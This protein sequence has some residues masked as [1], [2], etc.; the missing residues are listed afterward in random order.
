MTSGSNNSGADDIDTSLAPPRSKQQLQEQ[1]SSATATTSSWSLQIRTVNTKETD[2]F[3]V[4]VHPEDPIDKLYDKIQSHTGL[5]QQQQRLIYRGRLLMSHHSSSSNNENN[6]AANEQEGEGSKQSRRIRD[7]AGLCDGHCIH[8]VKRKIETT[9]GGGEADSTSETTRT[10]SSN[11]STGGGSSLLSAILG[12]GGSGGASPTNNN[13][14]PTNNNNPSNEEETEN[15]LSNNNNNNT[16]GSARRWRRFGRRGRAHYRLTAD[17]LEVPDPGSM[18]SV[19]QGLLTLHTLLPS[20]DH[21]NPLETNRTWYRGQ[22][23]DVRDTVNQWL[24]ATVVEIVKPEDVL[25]PRPNAMAAG[26][27]RSAVNTTPMTDPAVHA[28]DLNG[29]YRLLLEPCPEGC[30]DEDE[31]GAWDGFRRRASNA[32]AVLLLVHYNGWPHRWDEWIRSDSERLRPFRVRT[33]HPNSSARVSPTVQAPFA[34]Q[35]S[36]F[37]RG[38]TE[39]EDRQYVLPEVLRVMQQV[40]SLMEQAVGGPVAGAEATRSASTPQMLPWH[41]HIEDP[42]EDV[43]D[44]NDT[45][46]SS[47]ALESYAE[48]SVADAEDTAPDNT[49]RRPPPSRREQQRA[50]QAMAPL[51]DR[52]GRILV[53]AAPHVATLARQEPPSPEGLDTIDEHPSSLGGLLSMLSR[54]RRR[55]SIASSQ[56]VA[57]TNTVGDGQA[58]VT[59]HTVNSEVSIDPDYTDFAAGLVN[60]TRGEV[61]TGPRSRGSAGTDDISSLLGAYL[62]AAT[63]ASGDGNGNG[64]D[65]NLQLLGRILRDRDGS[66]GGGGGAGIDIHIHAVVTAPGILAEGEADGGG[67]GALLAGLGGGGGGATTA[68][69]MGNTRTGAPTL[70]DDLEALLPTARRVPATLQ[71]DDDL[72]I[73]SELYSENPEPAEAPASSRSSEDVITAVASPSS[74]PSRST[75]TSTSHRRSPR[76][77]TT[78]TTT[79][80]HHS[81]GV[82]TTNSQSNHNSS[83]NNS[84]S[85][86]NSNQ[87]RQGFLGRFLRRN[88]STE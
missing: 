87:R 23:L 33:R 28:D 19:R 57:S 84:S 30:P 85:T 17:D 27:T 88:Q 11:S 48:Q 61:R 14:L 71:Q 78:N 21:S 36:T 65:S 22:W 73:F 13:D 39:A 24:E 81:G 41:R 56:A 6:I 67:I 51:L 80:N 63:L 7:I 34:D 4:Q 43:V 75:Q 60:T 10:E 86:S 82:N 20:I 40:Q 64:D 18:E 46:E 38:A 68:G 50:L 72:G 5:S 74:S 2:D 32:N 53:D 12:L 58:T 3:Y 42:P 66:G 55:N 62:A 54:D 9:E 83:N 79:A 15:A 25:P 1:P 70:A 77:S 59:S 35:P 37:I 44:D 31:G 49:N 29:R 69:T 26:T 52:L 76:H 45:V 8:L 16:G 47:V